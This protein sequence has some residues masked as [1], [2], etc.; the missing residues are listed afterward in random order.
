MLPESQRKGEIASYPI[1]ANLWDRHRLLNPSTPCGESHRHRTKHHGGQHL[2]KCYG[3]FSP[4]RGAHTLLLPPTAC[5]D[6]PCASARRLCHICSQSRDWHL[7]CFP[8]A[9]MAIFLGRSI[10]PGQ[11]LASS[12]LESQVIEISNSHCCDM[13]TGTTLISD[14]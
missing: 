5:W 9:I 14:Q 6:T 1:T 7:S 11:S 8:G 2:C 13:L 10:S 4:F 12:G 3:F